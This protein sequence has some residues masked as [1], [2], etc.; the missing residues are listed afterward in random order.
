MYPAVR[1]PRRAPKIRSIPRLAA[2]GV[3]RWTG[4]SLIGACGLLVAVGVFTLLIAIQ[5]SFN[6][7]VTNSALGDAVA[8][9]VRGV[10]Y[11][12]AVMM[13]VLAGFGIGD[14]ACLDVIERTREVGTL[15]ASGWSEGHVR[16]LFGA[17]AM[18][19]VL[20]ALSR[21]SRIAPA[22]AINAE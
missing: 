6:G 20:V 11:F 2:S 13:L 17:E 21:L 8:L 7:A 15:R 16:R 10:D 14:V 5:R 9:Q 3:A 18:V 4:R 19:A 1:L 22:A 12:A